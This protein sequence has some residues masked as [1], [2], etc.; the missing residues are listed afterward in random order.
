MRLPS[1]FQ[2][3]VFGAVLSGTMS[4]IVCGVATY[5]ALGSFNGFVDTWWSAWLAAWP[6]AFATVLLVAP[7]VRRLTSQ[8]VHP[9][10]H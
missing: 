3:Y 7:L 8:I 10:S 5:R 6:V 4:F 9:A 2:P 1:Y